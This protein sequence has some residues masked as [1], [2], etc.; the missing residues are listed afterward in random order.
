[1]QDVRHSLMMLRK[2]PGYAMTTVLTLA[3]GIGACTSVFSIVN[4]SV[5]HP[6]AYPQLDRL[7]V[8]S[9]SY[10]PGDPQ[11]YVA[12][13][14]YLEFRKQATAFQS[15][16]GAYFVSRNILTNDG[17]PNRVWTEH[18][19]ADFLST[20]GVR[21]ALGRGFNHEEMTPGKDGVVILSHRLWRE[22]FGERPDIL[23]R[24]F[25]LDDRPVTIIGV[26]PEWF[27]ANS[28]D[29][30]LYAP[31]DLSDRDRL[32]RE[33][34]TPLLLLVV[35]RL[36]DGVSPAEASAEVAVISA[37]L[38]KET[39]ATNL[40]W[41]SS[42]EPLR[43]NTVASVRPLLFTL[44][45]AVGSLL[46]IACVN[47]ANLLLA[48]ATSRSK[49]IALRAALGATRG[50]ILRQFLCE[51]LILAGIGGGAGVLLAQGS[52]KLILAMA[53]V[54]LPRLGEIS[55]DHQVLF[56]SSALVLL[57]GL[58]FGM[59]PALQ[60]RRLNL[61]E[62][63]KEG[64]RGGSGGRRGMNTRNLLVVGEVALALMLLV[65]AGLL[66]RSFLQYQNIDYG[67]D[68]RK[69]FFTPLV[70][71]QQKYASAQSEINFLNQSLDRLR[72]LPGVRDASLTSRY[73]TDRGG[74]G[75]MIGG[76]GPD[77][78]STQSGSLVTSVS[79][80]YFRMQGIPLLR[81]RTT[82]AQDAAGT[83]PV[84]VV[85]EELARRYFPGVDP[86]GRRI[87]LM[88]DGEPAWREIAGMVGTIRD[89]SFAPGSAI[90]DRRPAIY[91]P[92]AQH[93][94]TRLN[95]Y[96]R[97]D[98]V[99]PLNIRAVCD[100]V[101]A[102]DRDVAI[103]NLWQLNV[104]LGGLPALRR[105][106]MRLAVAFS[107]I[108]L[109][110]AGIGIYGVM[111]FNVIQRTNEIGIRTALGAQRADV[112]R[113]ILLNGGRLVAGGI[114]IGVAGVLA[115]GRLLSSLLYNVSAYD[116]ITLG[117]ITLLLAAVAFAACWVPA[118]RAARVD[119]MVALRAE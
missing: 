6:F 33:H 102:T 111:A 80:G 49:E 56:F 110:L 108:A 83:E 114:L 82:T 25:L 21:P 107:F 37:R 96:V 42:V 2:N 26:M 17:D 13:G 24:T 116:P 59:A 51:S 113:L 43:E 68:R 86:I 45:G 48:R 53:P 117:G 31:Y 106:T 95:L 91:L 75:F 30:Q 70:L 66:T 78:P 100:A 12:S 72:H 52:L 46:L 90:P 94:L 4:L 28:P 10:L 99:L 88:I 109:I 35:G 61:N 105:F 118:M 18:L 98:P 16:A 93:P 101:H 69:L 47:I 20:L 89:F 97:S 55:V 29:P 3:L 64:G 32:S 22:E 41:G 57:T 74:T 71:P 27:Q 5:L 19:T 14:D 50:R 1:M 104:D 81:G 38:A 87:R 67:Y 62:V 15:L 65:S 39:P 119:P 11:D 44:M 115:G 112:M 85:N 23:G 54:N 92:F 40:G 36:K 76:Q 84:A 58:G 34:R 77:A 73:L 9:E 103:M 79:P 7:V 63:L 8:L 60:L